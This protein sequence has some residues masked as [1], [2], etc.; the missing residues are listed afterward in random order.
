MA[1]ES[2]KLDAM[3]PSAPGVGAEAHRL[4]D[5]GCDAGWVTE[6]AWDPFVSIAEAALDSSRLR[7]GTSIAV[8]LARNPMTLATT[9]NH[10]QLLSEGRFT[11]GLG[12]Q[13][14]AHVERRFNMP[15]SHPAPRMREFARAVRAIWRSWETGEPLDFTGEFYRHTLMAPLFD[16]GPNPYGPPPLYLSA[17]GPAMTEVAG[18]VAD[19][20]LVAPL[21]PPAYVRDHVLER[22]AAGRDRAVEPRPSLA[23]CAMPFVS[24]GRDQAEL[25]ASI[26]SNRARIAFYASTPSYFPVMDHVGLGGLQEKLTALS[27]Q[28]EW[29]QMT[30]AISD[31]VLEVFSV[32]GWCDEVVPELDRRYAG[33]VDRVTIY[34]ADGIATEVLA[35][36]LRGRGTGSAPVTS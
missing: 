4:E 29:E 18:E 20:F 9:A 17:V 33:L 21:A 31:D 16:P 13:V 27:K 8:A 34:S 26:E 15:W 5:I 7:L 3:L 2:L 30:A 32:V 22:L 12:S 25:D 24:T 28:R 6:T 10:L 14:K 36:I 23:V 19:G 1:T 11:V 35:E